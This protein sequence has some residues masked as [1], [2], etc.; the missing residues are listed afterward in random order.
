MK[1][2][3]KI[4]ER[5]GR[6]KEKHARVAQHYDVE[7]T[8]D[9]ESDKAIA[10]KWVRVEKA[11]SQASHPGVY[12]LRTNLDGWDEATLWKIYTML[13][14]LESVFRSLKSELGMRPVYHQKEKRVNGHIFITLIAY[15]LVQTLRFQL[16]KQ[17]IDDSW[18]TLRSKMENQQRVTIVLKKE[19]GSTLHIRKATRAEPF[20]K[21]IYDALSISSQPGSIQKTQQ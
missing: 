16:K 21:E 7:V 3:D 6:L 15:H 20:Q 17:G 13:T 2:Y 14:D 1:R 4:L 18:Q 19:D 5:I 8:Q 11:H 9:P 12:C 10:I